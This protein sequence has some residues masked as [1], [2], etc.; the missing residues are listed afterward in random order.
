MDKFTHIKIRIG[1]QNI[2]SL[3]PQ[4]DCVYLEIKDKNTIESMTY[5]QAITLANTL[6][7]LA[8]NRGI[9]ETSK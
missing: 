1:H 4:E 6:L 2:V 9:G 5:E 7:F 3:S 8:A